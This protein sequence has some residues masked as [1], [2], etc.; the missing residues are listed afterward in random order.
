VLVPLV[1]TFD[2]RNLRPGLG[3]EVVVDDE[4]AHVTQRSFVLFIAPGS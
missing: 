4:S 3:F 2:R 1:I